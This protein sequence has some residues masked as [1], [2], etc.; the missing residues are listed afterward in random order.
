MVGAGNVIYPWIDEKGKKTKL[1]APLFVDH[2]MTSIQK[3]ILDE[4]IFPTKYGNP[5][6]P[7]FETQARKITRWLF[8][9]TSHLY[10]SHYFQ[11]LGLQGIHSHLNT[12]F[13][14]L[15]LAFSLEEPLSLLLSD[16]EPLAELATI[17]KVDG[18]KEVVV[19]GFDTIPRDVETEEKIQSTF[20]GDEVREE[21]N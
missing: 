5:F 17:L 6:P 10:S 20:K 15:L 12:L 18:E 14:H 1:S 11:A 21:T 8:Q 4:N 2:V 13:V 3:I 16:N 7:S 9:V 19:D